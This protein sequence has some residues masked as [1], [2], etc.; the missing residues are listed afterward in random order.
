VYPTGRIVNYTFSTANRPVTAVDSASGTL[1]QTATSNG[2]TYATSPATLLSGCLS[3]AV[4]YT[5]QGSVYSMSIGQ[6]SSFTGLNV[7]ATFNNRLQP[8]EIKAS[9]TAGS[10][11][12]IT[13][14]FNDTIDF[15]GTTDHNA[16]HVYGITNNLNSSRSQAFSYDQLNRIISAG[17]TV[18]TGTYCWGYQYSY[19][20]WGNLLAQA[21]WTPTYTGCSETVMSAVTAN[22]ANQITGLSYDPSGNTVGDGNYSYTW[23]GESEM[24]SA[25]GVTYSY[26]GDGRRASKS[27]GKLYWY[28][29]GG[30]ILAETTASG[31]TTAE[32]VFFGGKRVA[33]L[34]AGSTAQYYVEDFLGSSRVMR[35]NTGTV[36]YDADFT[37][38]GGER[39]Y[40][41]TCANAYKF[42]GKERDA[43]TQNDDFGARYYTWRFGRWLSSDWSA[44]PVAVP[45]ANLTNPQTLNLYAMVADDP[46]TFA[47]LDGHTCGGYEDATCSQAMEQKKVESKTT[48]PAQNQSSGGFWQKLGNALS[49]NGWKTDS[50]VKQGQTTSPTTPIVAAGAGLAPGASGAA[51]AAKDA[52]KNFMK[53]TKPDPP[54]RGV[55][56][57]TP[58]VTKLSRLR[59]LMKD[60]LDLLGKTGA[61]AVGG[62]KDLVI[63]PIPSILLH[64]NQL[65]RDADDCHCT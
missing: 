42:E 12:D 27:N 54:L 29:S 32:Y 58:D 33:M 63:V 59:Q 21:G 62:A 45:Y 14:N 28:G 1:G 16:G 52:A 65:P 15:P 55:P 44:V 25:A 57:E 18:T 49:G 30:E 50:E 37:P 7:N 64:P 20:A 31:A 39:A 26:D 5:P 19:D 53:S 56:T 17:T 41:N 6:T 10:A 36:C 9:S 34:P 40:T 51:Q 22:N 2:I 24:T 3:G 48:T 60:A 13:Y 46:E 35:T 4:C 61:A 43:E 23:N 8:L 38:Y 11:L 47:D